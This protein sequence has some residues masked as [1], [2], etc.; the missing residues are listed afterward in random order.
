MQ[1]RNDSDCLDPKT[2]W[3]AEQRIDR[4][5]LRRFGVMEGSNDPRVTA[6]LLDRTRYYMPYFQ[7]VPHV[8]APDDA[9]G[10]IKLLGIV[11]SNLHT[12]VDCAR[13]ELQWFERLRGQNREVDYLRKRLDLIFRGKLLSLEPNYGFLEAKPRWHYW[14]KPHDEK[15]R[16]FEFE[17]GCGYERGKLAPFLDFVRRVRK[18]LMKKH[19]RAIQGFA[20]VT[21]SYGGAVFALVKMTEQ[22]IADAKINFAARKRLMA[23]E[24]AKARQEK[25]PER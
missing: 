13:K 20:V 4:E 12:A 24:E 21:G 25:K 23:I 3:Q 7:P 18:L 17:K 8:A 10:I 9:D 22:E 16:R 15:L 2:I 11:I 1:R 5:L 19:G 6:K 14:G